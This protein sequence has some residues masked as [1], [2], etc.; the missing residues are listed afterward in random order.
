MNTGRLCAIRAIRTRK[1]AVFAS[2]VST[3][4]AIDSIIYVFSDRTG[5][6]TGVLF[7]LVVEIS[8]GFVLFGYTLFFRVARLHALPARDH[9]QEQDD[10]GDDTNGY[11]L[12]H[13]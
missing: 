10:P 8:L 6:L 7:C 13:D 5:I 11:A 9:E 4:G 3:P 1:Y 12:F 2:N